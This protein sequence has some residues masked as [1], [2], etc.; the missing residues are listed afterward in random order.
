MAK[1]AMVKKVKQ[2]S[3]LI[4]EIPSPIIWDIL[5]RLPTKACLM[6]KLV[7]KDWYAIITDPEFADFRRSHGCYTT[8]LLRDKFRY[9]RREILVR[10][11]LLLDLY[12]HGKVDDTG[13]LVVNADEMIRFKTQFIIPN[14]QCLNPVND[15]NGVIFLKSSNWG[16]YVLCNLLTGQ[17]MIVKEARRWCCSVSG[18]GL[19]YCHFSQRFKVLRV[20]EC[21]RGVT[22]SYVTEIRII[23]TK[24]WRTISNTELVDGLFWHGGIFFK[25]SLHIHFIKEKCI[26]SFHFGY[27]KFVRIPL[28]GEI[29]RCSGYSSLCILD[30]CLCFSTVFKAD[31]RCDIWEMKDY[32]V[33]DSWVKLFVVKYT[34][35]PLS[36]S[37]LLQMGRLEVMALIARCD[38][39]S[40]G[41]SVVLT[42]CKRKVVLRVLSSGFLEL[43][44]N[45]SKLQK[46]CQK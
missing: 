3:C 18:V 7:C 32:E 36:Y 6:S 34:D 15:C 39:S 35:N 22:R 9:V 12:N 23:G 11:F 2:N 45:F 40:Y 4:E 20:L 37:P 14:Q 13:N 21:Y 27:E 8:V 24:K 10:D 28:P 42:E 5:S 17:Y 19:G 26:L 31:R 30:S 33:K 43:N 25:D 44:P 38:G 1:L 29:N 46:F 16:P 41:L